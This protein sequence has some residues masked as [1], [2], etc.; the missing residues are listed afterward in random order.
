MVYDHLQSVETIW[1][2]R[3]EGGSPALSPHPHS[4]CREVQVRL[5]TWK[6]SKPPTFRSFLF[7]LKLDKQLPAL[8]VKT[9]DWDHTCSPFHNICSS[10][11]ALVSWCVLILP[12]TLHAVARA[13]SAGAGIISA[14]ALRSVEYLSSPVKR[15][16]RVEK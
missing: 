12:T 14:D 15:N 8:A 11:F 6:L 7:D 9:V 2:G 16:S 13:V 5:S 1:V 10:L 3:E 4:Q